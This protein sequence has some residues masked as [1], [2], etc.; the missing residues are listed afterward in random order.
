M[1]TARTVSK[2]QIEAYIK[3]NWYKYSSRQLAERFGMTHDTINRWAKSLGLPSRTEVNIKYSVKDIKEID[4]HAEQKKNDK[5][6]I[7]ELLTENKKL[8][9]LL[10]VKE[11][12]DKN[13]KTYDIEY[14]KSK[15]DTEATAFALASDWHL[16]QKVEKNK[17]LF[18]N[19]YNLKIA[20]ERAKQFFQNLVKLLKKEQQNTRID[21][22]VLWLGGDFITG[23]IH[24][25]NLK[26]CQ[27]G[28]SQATV[29]AT[30][31][32]RSGIKYILDNTDVNLIIPYNHGNHARITEKVWLSTEEDNSL[33]YIIYDNLQVTFDIPR[34]KF[35]PPNGSTS[36]VEVYG[37]KVYF[38]HGHHGL[39][40]QGGIGGLYIPVR[41]YLSR[42]FSKVNNFYLLCI[43]HWHQYIQDTQFICNGSMI[44]Y[45]QYADSRGLEPD[46][47][48][49]TFF[50]I[51]RKRKCRTVTTPI[52]FDI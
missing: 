10:V 38:A 16:E 19:E 40:Y 26:V 37:L 22:L 13:F 44:G 21:T 36:M 30:N 11:T 46:I 5:K 34:V 28:V 31:I 3:K 15:N 42:K 6:L 24:V 35:V 7:K 52:T 33:E 27:L 14:K 9:Q 29:F 48:K 18:N 1:K 45:D 32:L 51:D 47:P 17:N 20:E 8:N 49:Q 2:K 43:G 39:N 23:N 50:L 41:K 12:V 4:R 25:E